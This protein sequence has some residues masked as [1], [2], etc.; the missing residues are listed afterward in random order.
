MSLTVGEAHHVNTIVTYWLR[1]A[2]D[3]RSVPAD[4]QVVDAMAEMA[5]RAT[6]TLMAGVNGNDVRKAWAH[7]HEA[8]R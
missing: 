4:D 6:K 5:D 8:G 2:R 1:I 7:R 3:G